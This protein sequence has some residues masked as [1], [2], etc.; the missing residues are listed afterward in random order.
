MF[1]IAGIVAL[2]IA[3]FLQ[4]TKGHPDAVIWLIIIGGILIGVEVAW[5]W[6]RGGR[7]Y[8]RGA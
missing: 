1:A 7:S 8:R 3:G 2:V 4:F 6:N 5:G